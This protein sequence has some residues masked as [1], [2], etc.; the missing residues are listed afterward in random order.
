MKKKNKVK[1]YYKLLKELWTIPRYRALIK[2]CLYGII[3]S[4]VSL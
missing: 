3:L 2:L 4:K 1:D